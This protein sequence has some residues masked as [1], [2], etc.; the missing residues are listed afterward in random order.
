MNSRYNKTNDPQRTG[1]NN[2]NRYNTSN[3]YHAS[4]VEETQAPTSTKRQIQTQTQL[5]ETRLKQHQDQTYSNNTMATLFCTLETIALR[6]KGESLQ[7]RKFNT[8]DF[9]KFGKKKDLEELYTQADI[10]L[11]LFLTSVQLYTETYKKDYDFPRDWPRE[12]V[13]AFLKS[14]QSNPSLQPFITNLRY[15]FKR[16]YS[17]VKLSSIPSKKEKKKKS[18]LN[19]VGAFLGIRVGT[20]AMSENAKRQYEENPDGVG[21]SIEESGKAFAK[22]LASSKPKNTQEEK[23]KREFAK[24]N[25]M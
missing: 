11:R 23:A 12:K 18:F 19:K 20:D 5:S 1:N 16:E 17:K 15:I 24:K 10:Q 9:M 4:M 25:L 13:E 3:G 8:H 21:V 6:E 2:A 14:I 7:D 22:N